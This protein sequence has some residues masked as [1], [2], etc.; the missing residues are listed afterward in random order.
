M[1][2][3]PINASAAFPRAYSIHQRRFCRKVVPSLHVA[4]H[5]Y[6]QSA[7]AFKSAAMQQ[8]RRRQ[9]ESQ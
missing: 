9:I 5:S 4:V 1:I 6:V 2:L 3:T 7:C 8:N